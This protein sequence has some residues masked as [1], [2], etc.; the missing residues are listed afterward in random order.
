[1]KKKRNKICLVR[2]LISPY[3]YA[4]IPLNL[5]ILGAVLK[6]SNLDIKVLD[7]DNRKHHNKEILNMKKSNT[8]MAKE[9]LKESP[10][11]VAITTMCNNY[12]NV[13]N[14][15]K[16]IKDYNEEISIILGGPQASMAYVETIKNY[17]YID[18]I[19]IGEGENTLFELIQALENKVDVSGID[20]ICYSVDEEIVITP[21]RELLCNLDE[22][23]VPDYSLINLE[24]YLKVDSKFALHIGTGCPFNCNFCTTSLMWDKRYRVKS[25][26]RIIDEIV[27]L[28]EKYGITHFDFTHDNLTS[29]KNFVKAL[30]EQIINLKFDIRFEFSSRVDTIDHEVIQLASKAGCINIFFGIEHSSDRIQNVIGKK[31]KISNIHYI[32]EECKRKDIRPMTSFILGFPEETLDDLNNNIAFAFKTR[33]LTSEFTPLNLLSV[34]TGSKL[35]EEVSESLVF[36][37]TKL[38]LTMSFFLNKNYIQEIKKNK[39]IYCNYYSIEYKDPVLNK[40][41]FAILTEFAQYTIEKFTY[42]FNFLINICGICFTDIY[43]FFQKKLKKRYSE[44]LERIYN[45]EIFDLKLYLDITRNNFISFCYAQRLNSRLILD[46]EKALELD[47]TIDRML[48]KESE[49]TCWELM[50]CSV[51]PVMDICEYELFNTQFYTDTKILISKPNSEIVIAELS[52]SEYQCL[53]EYKKTGILIKQQESVV[54]ELISNG[55]I[56]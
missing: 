44:I 14:I 18:Y 50:E 13:L 34:Y 42:S 41:N 39:P 21:K 20:G 9:I 4:G 16:T 56:D 24:E 7:F 17:K 22:S 45:G 55:I 12:L 26:D 31:L 29:N 1:M 43:L 8:I 51:N 25:V 11:Y 10:K 49:D 23:P 15:A 27:E 32:I 48:F 30:L 6:K 28:K 40:I 5:L 53:E 2:P 35:F 52:T 3:E 46:F 19:I 37:P 36:D 33:L 54:K 47:L 38:N